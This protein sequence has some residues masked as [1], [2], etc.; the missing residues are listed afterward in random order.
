VIS[1]AVAE[2]AIGL[3]LSVCRHIPDMHSPMLKGNWQPLMGNELSGK[4]LAIVGCG[5]I[6]NRVAQIAA[7][8]FNMKVFGYDIQE[9]DQKAMKQK[10]G[11]SELYRSYSN[12]LFNADF[13][14]FH[15]PLNEA[16]SGLADEPFFE[17]LKRSP[18]IINTARG[19]V[20]DEVAL[21]K[22]LNSGLVAGAALDVFTEEPYKPVSP[23]HDLR[24]CRN[25]LMTPH[26][27][28]TTDEACRRMAECCVK[29]IECG[30]RKEYDKMDRVMPQA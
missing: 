18:W 2:L 12:E 24:K 22:A 3:M 27:G 30:E 23:D 16:T 13:I 28:T 25:V 15:V 4:N 7:L 8:G 26:V 9:L 17:Q 19:A 10:F 21:V 5:A 11:Y 20:I 29:N 1:N 14:S 6:G